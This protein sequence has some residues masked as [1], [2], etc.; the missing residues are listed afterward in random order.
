[1]ART[2]KFNWKEIEKGKWQVDVPPS[3]S[4]TGKRERHYFTTR[5]KAK[6]HAQELREKF[7]AHGANAQAIKPSLAEAAVVA[8]FILA[9]WG[10]SLVEAARFYAAARERQSAS[11]PLAEATAAFLQSC[12]G[13]RGRTIEGYRQT[14][15]RLDNALADKVLAT[16]SADELQ[17][18]VAPAGT[19]GAAAANRYRCA[20]AFWRWSAKKGWCDAT[21]FAA[22]EAPR[23]SNDGEIS[24]L[25][26]ADA[27]ALL[28]AAETHFP[29]AVATYA[30]QLFAGIR[31]EEIARLEAG[32]VSP[33]GIELG[34]S[35]TKKN[36]R[37]H[38]TLSPTLAAWIEVHPFTPCPNW[39]EV[40]DACRRMAGWDI[41][42]RILAERVEA[43]K[44][45]AMPK[46]TRGRWPQNVLRHSF[47]S[48]A[49]AGGATL[50]EMLFTFGH[51]GGPA[52]LRSNYVGK[53]TKKAALEFFAIRPAGTEAATTPLEIVA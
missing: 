35:I 46:P 37:R 30:L 22:V 32:N 5:D 6:E 33:D 15:K 28:R 44:L 38:I 13:L 41:A 9:P 7:L 49:I 24:V 19:P 25:S 10:A 34:A 3:V 29:Q 26:I 16:V 27:K 39:R 14:C 48:Y 40:H 23:V 42:A 8:E 31:V 4:E 11:K 51:S 53:V 1:M 36:R 52:L 18:A 21:T 43:G 45:K 17:A 50:E 47:A 12:E 20:R 2:P